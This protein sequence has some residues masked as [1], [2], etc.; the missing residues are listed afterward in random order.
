MTKPGVYYLP[1]ADAIWL[2]EKIECYEDLY[3]PPFSI[4]SVVILKGSY[5]K[6]LIKQSQFKEFKR[7]GSL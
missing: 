4:V 1:R 5:K 3:S 7:I 2:V 6:V